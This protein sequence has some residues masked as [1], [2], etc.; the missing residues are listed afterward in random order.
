MK[1]SSSYAFTERFMNYRQVQEV[2]RRGGC[3][4]MGILYMLCRYLRSAKG[5]VGLIEDL[6]SVADEA[7]MYESSIKKWMEDSNIF[8]I[9][10]ERGIFYC[11]IYRHFLGMPDCPSEE[12]IEQIE[13][14]GNTYRY[15]AVGDIHEESNNSSRINE[16]SS[17]N[18]SRINEESSKNDSLNSQMP[19]NKDVEPFSYMYTD[20][21]TYTDTDISLLRSE[22]TDTDTTSSETR[23][24]DDGDDGIYFFRKNNF[25]HACNKDDVSESLCINTKDSVTAHISAQ[26]TNKRCRRR[27]TMLKKQKEARHNIFCINRH[28]THRTGGK[29]LSSGRHRAYVDTLKGLCM[30]V[31]HRLHYCG[32]AHAPDCNA[33]PMHAPPGRQICM[34]TGCRIQELSGIKV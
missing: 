34:R 29:Q 20:T 2:I 3:K 21:D 11:C 8:V 15:K 16:D 24:T 10:E 28:D 25:S 18:E 7:R 22:N 1:H 6:K 9:D 12:E 4:A 13:R 5:A 19:D 31:S 30:N 26:R 17:K 14:D 32:Q 33:V 23:E 27:R